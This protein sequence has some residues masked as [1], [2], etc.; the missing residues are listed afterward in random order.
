MYDR[1][2]RPT[3]EG[4]CSVTEGKDGYIGYL[5]YSSYSKMPFVGRQT[6]QKQRT[7]SAVLPVKQGPLV[8]SPI[9]K[10]KLIDA[11]IFYFS[12]HFLFQQPFHAIR[13]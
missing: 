1:P 7:T 12:S 5:T 6:S 8:L 11:A 9:V 13:D 2:C 3:S 4:P 10:S